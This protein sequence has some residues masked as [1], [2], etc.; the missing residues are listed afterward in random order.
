MTLQ[1]RLVLN[2]FSWKRS[3]RIG[4][5]GDRKQWSSQMRS[6]TLIKEDTDD[7]K[8]TVFQRMDVITGTRWGIPGRRDEVE[9]QTTLAAQTA[10]QAVQGTFACRIADR[11]LVFAGWEGQGNLGE[12]WACCHRP[13]CGSRSFDLDDSDSHSPSSVK[14]NGKLE[15]MS[16]TNYLKQIIIILFRFSSLLCRFFNLS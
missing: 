6:P 8:M 3:H 7:V 5:T 13:K 16:V 4:N 10:D 15:R 12:T 14:K 9:A 11:D 1:N 2:S